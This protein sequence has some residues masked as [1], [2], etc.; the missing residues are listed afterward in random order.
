MSMIRSVDVLVIGAGPAGLATSRELMRT[1]IE[2]VVLERGSQ[3][4][5]TWANLY[6]S[7]VLHTTRRLSALPGL[8]FPSAT[9]L[10]PTRATFLEYLHRYAHEF[11]L[12]IRTGVEVRS[13]Q[14]QNGAWVAAI[15]TG[16]EVQARCAVVATGIVSNPVRPEIPH[17]A[18]FGGDVLHSVDYR[19]PDGFSGRRVLV[20]G[21]GN[22]A[23]EIAAEL[24]RAG[25][26]VTI[27]VRSGALVAPREIAGVPI[28]YLAVMLA[29]LPKPVQRAAGTIV[30]RLSELVRGPAVLPRAPNM[31]CWQAPLIGF[32]LTNAIRNG[33][34][35]VQGGL[36]EFTADGV[37]FSNGTTQAF[38]VVMLATGYRAALGLL[39]PMVRTDACGFALRQGPVVSA[40]DSD[41]CFVGHNYDLRGGLLNIGRDA[42]HVARRLASQLRRRDT[43]RTSTET[44]RPPRER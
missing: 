9:P 7:L 4:G 31:A 10:F 28:Q 27:A 25:A 5:E 35:R 18:R 8:A 20:V 21:A 22:S 34:I 30:G 44:T 42:R 11:R 40:D 12:P 23:G 33:A 38:D 1:G 14:R 15:T 43:S 26:D 3:V 37:K 6:D 13:L 32:H 29:G 24:A 19:R 2:H 16:G 41:L 17:R 36:S 39:G